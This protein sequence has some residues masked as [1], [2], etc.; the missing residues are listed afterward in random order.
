[1]ADA[2]RTIIGLGTPIG[3]SPVVTT[4]HTLDDATDA[5]EVLF[6]PPEAMTITRL[7]FRYNLTTGDP[8]IYVAE[9]R[10]LDASGLPGSTLHASVTF[11]PPADTSWDGTWRWF[12]L[13]TPYAAVRGEGLVGRVIY[14]SGTINASN[15]A[16]FTEN[17]NWAPAIANF[18][19]YIRNSAG[20]RTRLNSWPAC[21]AWGTAT[22]VYGF[23]LQSVYNQQITSATNP[24]E[25]GLRFTLPAEWGSSYT[26]VGVRVL[27]Q[28]TFGHTIR[29]TLYD[30]TTPLQQ[31]DFDTD[32]AT[33]NAAGRITEIMFDETNLTTLNFGQ[34]YRIAFAPQ[35]TS[36]QRFWGLTMANAADLDAYSLGTNAFFTSREEGGAW[37][38]DTLTRPMIE[39]VLADWT[40]PSGGAR[41]W[42]E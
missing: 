19:H 23:P 26:I 31:V 14:S 28:V 29:T 8:P 40:K 15:C 4:H 39:L 27:M 30:G 38:D 3:G 25:V 37:T 41:R 20:S 5:Y 1:M 17:A 42:I 35:S 24:D 33:T 36:N 18:P 7:G 34:S 21:F 12:T 6:A 16:Q 22:R 10:D 13:D 32:R 11:D 9:L 2:Q